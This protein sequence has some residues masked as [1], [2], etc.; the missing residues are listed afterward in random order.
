MDRP[1]AG[2]EPLLRGERLTRSYVGEAVVDVEGIDVR[3][4]EVLAVLGPNGAGKSTLMRLLA[5]L[6]GV[7]RYSP[8]ELLQPDLELPTG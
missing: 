5:G 6:E 3:A 4:G 8:V 2:A 1:V 7:V